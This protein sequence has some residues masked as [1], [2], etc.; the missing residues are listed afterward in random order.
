M[1][2]NV[3]IMWVLNYIQGPL[4]D[5]K[6]TKWQE[7]FLPYYLEKYLIEYSNTL[8]KP[9]VG[10]IEVVNTD[11]TRK[12]ILDHNYP[13]VL[14][15][16]IFGIVLALVTYIL[17]TIGFKSKKTFLRVSSRVLIGTLLFVIFTFLTIISSALLFMMIFSNHDFA[18]NNIN[19]L[20][21]NPILILLSINSLLFIFDKINSYQRIQKIS[22]FF[23]IITFI[24]LLLPAI[25]IYVF[26]QSNLPI[27]L[28]VLPL[29]LVLGFTNNI[30]ETRVK[31]KKVK[32]SDIIIE[33]EVKIIESDDDQDIILEPFKP[34]S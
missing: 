8:E 12:Q 14:V 27:I 4:I 28:T 23:S 33:E 18:Y 15:S 30:K 22:R 32:K 6:I 1:G 3:F 10:D 25:S 2:N 34:R 5:K 11:K 31:K 20:F 16:F 29:Y 24:C 7:M 26:Y 19:I 9:L 17:I 13:V 21:I